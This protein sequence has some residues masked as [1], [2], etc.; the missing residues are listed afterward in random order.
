MR[1]S[2]PK[3]QASI[4]AFD[5]P[6][7]MSTSSLMENPEQS[8]IVISPLASRT[9]EGKLYTRPETVE[10]ELL[11]VLRQDP[12]EWI[13]ARTTLKSESLVFLNRHIR[14]KDDYT[15]GRLQLEVNAR[16]VRM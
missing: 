9:D 13:K 16:T 14:R 10:A 4:A 6:L 2:R 12:A 8:P 11:S 7:R 15:A 5:S 1:Q 3:S